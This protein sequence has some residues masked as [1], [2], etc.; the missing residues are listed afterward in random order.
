[1]T[2]M[3][4]R[5]VADIAL[6]WVGLTL[7]IGFLGSLFFSIGALLMNDESSLNWESGLFLFLLQNLVM[8]VFA[9]ILLFRR[10]MILDLLF[11]RAGE[12]ELEVS[13]GCAALTDLGFWIRLCGT[14][15]FITS[16]IGALAALASLRRFWQPELF[17]DSMFWRT[18]LP[19]I[20]SVIASLFVVQ[21][22]DR[23][24]GLMKRIAR[25]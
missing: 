1:M 10:D 3:T 24:A 15:Q 14:L 20:V 21:Q 8:F 12:V 17:P 4:K 5:D 2:K 9:F 16:F 18:M 6:V 25:S 7:F 13:D 23:I 11:P 22:A 19:K